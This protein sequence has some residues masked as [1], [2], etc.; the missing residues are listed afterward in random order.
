MSL[1]AYTEI[2]PKTSNGKQCRC[3]S[4]VARKQSLERQEPRNKPL[5]VC[6]LPAYSMGGLIPYTLYPTD[7]LSSATVICRLNLFDF[8][9]VYLISVF[10]GHRTRIL[11]LCEKVCS[12]A[13]A[14][15]LMEGWLAF[16]PTFP[17]VDIRIPP[18]TGNYTLFI[19][20]FTGYNTQT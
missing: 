8:F 18:L 17:T 3:R 2:Q 14:S 16:W 1:S 12:L 11:F 7:P 20:V 4:V 10:G 9:L 5:S 19:Y 13:Y 15:L 6:S